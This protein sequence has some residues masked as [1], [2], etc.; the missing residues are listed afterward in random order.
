MGVAVGGKV[1]G[2]H[3]GKELAYLSLTLYG[4]GIE[5]WYGVLVMPG[6]VYL[7]CLSSLERQTFL[8]N[9]CSGE[10]YSCT[11]KTLTLS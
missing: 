8:G 5:H 10:S 1:W 7:L 3:G 11:S 4:A 9:R 2:L 6:T